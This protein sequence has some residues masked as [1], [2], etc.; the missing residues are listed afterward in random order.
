VPSYHTRE[1]HWYLPI[2][3]VDP[4]QYGKGL[5]SFLMQY[6]A[7]LFDP[8]NVVAC[9]ELSNAKNILF[10]K[11]HGFELLGTIQVGGSPSIYPMLRKPRK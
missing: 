5:G 9:L 4:L 11:R 3:G 2:L 7:P 8:E 1:P 10:Y 6:A